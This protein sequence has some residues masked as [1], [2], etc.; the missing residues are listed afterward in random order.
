MKLV[1]FVCTFLA[2]FYVLHG[3]DIVAVRTGFD[4]HGV[5]AA[6]GD[7]NAD[8][9]VD[10]FVISPSG[11]HTTVYDHLALLEKFTTRRY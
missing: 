5:V 3:F 9:L 6:F 7:Y 1:Y 2:H 11:R 4:N 10:V 8:K